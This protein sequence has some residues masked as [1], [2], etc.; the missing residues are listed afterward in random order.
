MFENHQGSLVWIVT[1]PG[2]VLVDAR[3]TLV[4]LDVNLDHTHMVSVN[5][6]YLLFFLRNKH[7]GNL[8]LEDVDQEQSELV[9]ELSNINK[10][11]KSDKKVFYKKRGIFS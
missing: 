4:T 10:G 9:I 5:I 6:R 3:K 1:R 2:N 8:L 7:E 11:G